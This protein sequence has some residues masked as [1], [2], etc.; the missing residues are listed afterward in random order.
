LEWYDVH[1]LHD[2][3]YDGFGI[4]CNEDDVELDEFIANL[5]MNNFDNTL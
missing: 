5:L 4:I 1:Y 2:E 3:E